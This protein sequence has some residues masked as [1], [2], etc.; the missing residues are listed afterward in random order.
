MA[1]ER[2]VFRITA[3]GAEEAARAIE[4]MARASKQADAAERRLD[5]AGRRVASTFDRT[6][7]SARG[8]TVEY[9]RQTRVTD[10][11]WRSTRNLGIAFTA[12]TAVA[13]GGVV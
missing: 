8:V 10:R 13:H 7:S 11:L 1:E 4:R 5:A 12:A 2:V 9:E 6:R 3:P